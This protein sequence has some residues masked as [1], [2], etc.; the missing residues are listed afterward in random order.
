MRTDSQLRLAWI[1]VGRSASSEIASRRDEP[2]EGSAE[3]RLT[4]S[5]SSEGFKG[6]GAPARGRPSTTR[7]QRGF[8]S[9]KHL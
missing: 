7:A 2:P 5:V 8:R 9:V 3:P 6:R 4:H 1:S